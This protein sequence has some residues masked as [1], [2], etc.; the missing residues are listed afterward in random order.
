MDAE[1]DEISVGH[2]GN[3]GRAR[4][5]GDRCCAGAVGLV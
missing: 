4:R 5:F 3:V 2:G 1:V